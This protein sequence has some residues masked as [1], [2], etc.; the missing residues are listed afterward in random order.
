MSNNLN[1]GPLFDSFLY[2]CKHHKHDVSPTSL[3][4]GLPLT[5]SV[6]SPNVLSRLARRAGMASKLLNRSIADFNP[7]LFPAVLLL[8]DNNACIVHA[9]DQEKKT[10]QVSFSE[11][12]ENVVEIPVA[13]L[14]KTYSGWIWYTRPQNDA[15][16]KQNS[17]G[18]PDHI[19]WFW[20]IIKQNTPLYRDVLFAA[21]LINLFALAMPMYV[22]NI[23]D[24]VVPN[25][26]ID[27]LWVLSSGIILVLLA[28]TALKLLRHFFIDKAANKSDILISSAIM[29]KILTMQIKNKPKATG[30]FAATIQSFEAVRSFMSSLTLVALADLPFVLM[31]CV[32]IGLISFPLLAPI[33]IAAII[34]LIYGFI[35]QRR[36]KFLSETAAHATALRNAAL[37]DTLGSLDSIKVHNV[38]SDVQA[39]WEKLNLICAHNSEKIR[40]VGSSVANI[41]AFIQQVA[42]VAVMIVGV[43]LIIDGSLSQGGLI[44]V[45]MLSARALT[46]VSQAAG[47]LSQYHHAS[48]AME[49]LDQI[50]AMPIEQPMSKKSLDRPLL[51]GSIEFKKVSFSY[52]DADHQ[53]L[54]QVSFKIEPG[55]HVAIL[56]RN[57]S[58]KSTLE[59]LVLGLYKPDEGQVLIDGVDINLL[60]I[61]QVRQNIG[62]VPQDISL[63]RGS[64]RYNVELNAT[65][66]DAD[67]LLRICEIS[68]LTSVINQHPAGFNLEVGERGQNLSGGQKQLVAIAR[69]LYPEPRILL[70]DE[71][72]AALD[73]SSEDNFRQKLADYAK[74]KTLIVVTHRSPLLSLANRIIVIDSGKVLADG[75]KETVLEALRQGRIMGAV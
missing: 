57:G 36:L 63:F 40:S 6:V 75:P 21:V 4:S 19:H 32:V 17:F 70:L 22:M 13:E 24:R 28:D 51:K 23:Y 60:D 35:V 62:Y 67:Q 5:D 11:L 27:T 48:A 42:T 54:N 47:L 29:D 73:H 20:G 59:K 68:G 72:T 50:M 25:F 53:S 46:P 66:Q 39:R 58:G 18:L 64:L 16:Q 15:E 12:P 38:G 61:N 49:N 14:D 43:Y 44:A 26:A 56:G 71:P 10:V 37:I 74:G 34:A 33:V 55:E 1:A 31:Y 9:V 3:L 52:P 2:I 41:T 7:A 69:A 30:S 65:Q 45:F 8:R